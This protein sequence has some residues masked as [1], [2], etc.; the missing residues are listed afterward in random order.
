MY[1]CLCN[2]HTS[3]QLEH[4]ARSGVECVEKA[5][6]LLGG[7][8]ECRRCI[9]CAK[10]IMAKARDDAAPARSAGLAVSGALPA[11]ALL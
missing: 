8:P 10:T 4:I 11:G 2:G 3:Q 1:V 9:D 5:Y 7:R 6:E